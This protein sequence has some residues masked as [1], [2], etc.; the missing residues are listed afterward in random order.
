MGPFATFHRHP[1]PRRQERCRDV[2]W[3]NWSQWPWPPRRVARSASSRTCGWS[4]NVASWPLGLGDLSLGRFGRSCRWGLG[5]DVGKTSRIR[6]EASFFFFLTCCF[7]SCIFC[8]GWE[9]GDMSWW[10]NK[11]QLHHTR[12]Q[13]LS[14]RIQLCDDIDDGWWAKFCA[15]VSRGLMQYVGSLPF[16]GRTFSYVD[17]GQVWSSLVL[18]KTSRPMT[19]DHWA[20]DDAL[21][22]P[23]SV[24]F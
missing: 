10:T 14:L 2:S 6:V 21:F 7:Y 1:A 4:S 11:L 5:K 9:F 12:Q 19:I 23:N 16:A 8:V 13:H 15:L 24:L 18:Y 3:M 17:M 20:K 22:S